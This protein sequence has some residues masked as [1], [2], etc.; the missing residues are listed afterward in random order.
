M[1]KTDCSKTLEILRSAGPAGVHSFELNRLVGT[2][3]VG[4]RVYDLK[5]KGYEI[6]AVPERM[7]D[8]VGVRYFLNSKPEPRYKVIFDDAMNLARRVLV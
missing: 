7:G 6:T 4:A 3:R 1:P 2:I 5:R 8:A